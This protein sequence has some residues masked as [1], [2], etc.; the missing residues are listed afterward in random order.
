MNKQ[1]KIIIEEWSK[2]TG[3]VKNFSKKSS[4]IKNDVEEDFEED[5]EEIKNHDVEI[6]S[7]TNYLRDVEKIKLYN[8]NE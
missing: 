3:Q 2:I 8:K 4:L 6:D 5:I 7:F 1:D